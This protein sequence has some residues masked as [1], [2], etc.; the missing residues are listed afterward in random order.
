MVTMDED[1]QTLVI[2]VGLGKPLAVYD[3]DKMAGYCRR[4]SSSICEILILPCLVTYSGCVEKPTLL[5][6]DKYGPF[7]YKR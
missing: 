5:A 3:T 7:H 1:V 6:L 2:A 4:H